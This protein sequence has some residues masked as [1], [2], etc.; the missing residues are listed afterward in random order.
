M[1]EAPSGTPGPGGRALESGLSSDELWWDPKVD[2]AAIAVSADDGL[3]T[4]RGTVARFRQRLEAENDAKRVSGVKTVENELQVEMLDQEEQL[5]ADV[6][7]HV[8]QALALD[9]LV[10]ETLDVT[11]ED[12]VVTLTG[13]ADRQYER[14][15]AESVA[16]NIIGALGVINRIS[17]TSKSTAENVQ[18]SICDAFRRNA[19]LDAD[20]LPVTTS[21]GTVT[22]SGIV[23]SWAEHDEAID[24][25]WA[26]PGVTMVEDGVTV[27]Y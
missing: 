15:E 3:V 22:V 4:L 14:R 5:D 19:R 12:G 24:A 2:N 18:D 13:T 1:P 11:V 25:A 20:R 6:R 9:G 16:S 8:L 27:I 10:P 21:K 26:A 23:R 17:L 7:A